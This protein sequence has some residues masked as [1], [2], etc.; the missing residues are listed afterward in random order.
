MNKVRVK[1]C[2]LRK[3]EDIFACV[4]AGAD[5]LGF[6]VDV[7]SSPRNLSVDTAHELM[8]KVPDPTGK[9][10]VTVRP[11]AQTEKKLSFI[12]RKLTPDAIQV[13]GH[14]VHVPPTIRQNFAE[15][16]FIGALPIQDESS[17]MKGLAISKSFDGVHADSY[18][19]GQGGG[20]GRTHDWSLSARLRDL[21]EPVPLTLAGGLSEHNVAEAI[22]IV[23]P[24]AVDASS[25]VE[26]SLGMKD[27][28]KIIRFVR[29]AKEV[30]LP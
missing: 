27:R 3:E 10:V 11:H 2:G 5:Y 17:L 19:N 12:L 9:V 28:K 15:V 22:R 14:A 21:I 24:F 30:K 26:S 4:D 23:R 20:T 6:V 7:P 8:R 1:I 29:R 16:K 18:V 25:G 13:H